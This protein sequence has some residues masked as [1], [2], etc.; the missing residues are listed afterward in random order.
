M[1]ARI[2]RAWE[3]VAGDFWPTSMR[4]SKR[5]LWKAFY[6]TR[7]NLAPSDPAS[8]AYGG[9]IQGLLRIS[10]DFQ[11]QRQGR[12]PSPARGQE[13]DAPPAGSPQDFQHPPI[14]GEQ[15]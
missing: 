15:G 13:V 12:R 7:V 3:S 5:V 9:R 1:A 6:R 2:L 8:E 14:G 10:V 11:E 4:V